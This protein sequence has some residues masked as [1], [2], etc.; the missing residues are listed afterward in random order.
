MWRKFGVFLDAPLTQ[1]AAYQ[2][3]WKDEKSRFWVLDYPFSKSLNLP[4]GLA[5]ATSQGVLSQGPTSAVEERISN[6]RYG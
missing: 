6:G 2:E 5:A 3:M 1:G 4:D